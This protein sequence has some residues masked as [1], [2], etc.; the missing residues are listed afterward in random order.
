M[1]DLTTIPVDGSRFEFTFAES[2][3]F[4]DFKSGEQQMDRVDG[5]PLWLVVALFKEVGEDRSVGRGVG[6]VKVKVPSLTPFDVVLTPFSQIS[7]DGLT[8]RP[9]AMAQEGGRVNDGLTLTASGVTVVKP[10]ANGAKPA[11]PIEQTP[12]AV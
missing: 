4:F 1:N 2:G 11:K 7:F 8:A 5:R 3:P 9:Y 10:S 12:A 6:M